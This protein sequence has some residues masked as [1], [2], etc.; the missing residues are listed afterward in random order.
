MMKDG[1]ETDVDCGGGGCNTCAAGKACL[2]SAD[3]TSK[4]CTGNLCQAQT[5]MD[6]V[7]NGTETDVDCG[8][9]CAPAIKCAKG[10]KGNLDSDCTSGVC[11]VSKICN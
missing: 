3:C 9:S 1:K 2:T 5:C 8:G 11:L 4:V 10:K 6:M 7:Q